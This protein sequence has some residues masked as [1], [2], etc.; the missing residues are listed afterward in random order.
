MEKGIS[1]KGSSYQGKHLSQCENLEVLQLY[2]QKNQI[3]KKGI[4]GL[5]KGIGLCKNLNNLQIDLRSNLIESEGIS[6]LG[7]ELSNLNKLDNL[8]IYFSKNGNLDSG[9]IGFA[10]GIRSCIS[11]AKVCLYF[12]QRENKIRDLGAQSLGQRFE[13]FQKLETLVIELSKK[14][15]S[16]KI[17]NINFFCIKRQYNKQG[18]SQQD[19]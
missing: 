10:Y 3:T 14:I 11:L 5:S 2:L 4:S 8:E 1:D 7:K 15:S 9:L 16:N 18:R 13:L 12:Y 19:I 6:C 17:I